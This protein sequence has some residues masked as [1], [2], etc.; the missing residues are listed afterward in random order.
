MSCRNA[1]FTPPR[2]RSG[3]H[4]ELPLIRFGRIHRR[5]VDNSCVPA[6]TTGETPKFVAPLF[7]NER[8]RS[9][10]DNRFAYLRLQF[11][12]VHRGGVLVFDQPGR[13]MEIS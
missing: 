13:S 10:V 1:R 2:N 11:V 7:T 12:S 6:P 8:S 4:H 3:D 5:C 9:T